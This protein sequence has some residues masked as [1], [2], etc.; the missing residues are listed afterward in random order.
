MSKQPKL[1]S[2]LGFAQRA[3]ALASGE[4]AAEAALRRGKAFLC[5]LSADASTNTAKKFRHAAEN[6]G[7]P[8]M[9][10]PSKDELG[11]WIGKAQRSVVVVTDRKFALSIQKAQS[12]K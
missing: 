6:Q 2:L 5:I 9:T 3:S 11:H 1:A 4:Q 10:G 12:E 8:L 7:I